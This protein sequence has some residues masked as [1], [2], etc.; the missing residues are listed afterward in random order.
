M[1]RVSSVLALGLAMAVGGCQRNGSSGDDSR[2]QLDVPVAPEVVVDAAL[3]GPRAL[4]L[5]ELRPG[6]PPPEIAGF[7]AADRQAP[8]EVT[9][10]RLGARQ[11]SNARARDTVLGRPSLAHAVLRPA[12]AAWLLA[13]LASDSY[14]GGLPGCVESDPLGV[15]LSRGDDRLELVYTCGLL[16]LTPRGYDGPSVLLDEPAV[17]VLLRLR[18]KTGF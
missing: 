18:R 12:D 5:D 8:I 14:E 11:P 9:F 6:P 13:T 3:T 16:L 10:H 7:L 2:L 4:T 17:D 1:R 15:R